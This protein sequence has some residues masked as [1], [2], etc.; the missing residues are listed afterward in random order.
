MKPRIPIGILIII[1]LF[2]LTGFIG[3]LNEWDLSFFT[4]PL[5]WAVCFIIIFLLV[6]YNGV[7]TLVESEKYKMLSK[8]KQQEFLIEK[9]TPFMTRLY[10]SA[11]GRQSENEEG[12]ILL[13]HDYDGIHELDNKLP[14]WWLSLFYFGC[15][16]LVIYMVAFSFTDFA[17][18]EAEFQKFNQEHDREVE[19]YLATVP[20]VEPADMIFESSNK[21]AGKKI[22]NDNCVVCHNADGGAGGNSGANLTDDYWRNINKQELF[23]NIVD[24]VWNGSAY[25]KTM[26]GF[27]ARGEILGN[28]IEKLAAY[29]TILNEDTNAPDGKEPLGSIVKE[30]AKDPLPNDP[31]KIVD[32]KSYFENDAAAEGSSEANP[33][34]EDTKQEVAETP[35]S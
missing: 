19:Q 23:D 24:V 17:H 8:A 3:I 35:G 28:D 1:V 7:S 25:D 6:I 29:V 31:S 12:E 14:Q 15:F 33:E 26:R 27:G 11:F 5:Y 9:Q 16:F 13:N 20:Q 22:F 34:S 18:P 21:E 32:V 4:N 10:K 30:W 2:V